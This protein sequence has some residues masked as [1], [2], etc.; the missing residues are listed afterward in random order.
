MMH[1]NRHSLETQEAFAR[2][3]CGQK[4]KLEKSIFSKSAAKNSA[5]E[6]SKISAATQQEALFKIK[7]HKPVNFKESFWRRFLRIFG[8]AGLIASLA[9]HAILFIV[10]GYFIIYHLPLIQPD[11]PDAFVTG[12]G[13]GN[14]GTARERPRKAPKVDVKPKRIASKN[15]NGKIVLPEIN[16]P[17][18]SALSSSI[19]A[20][21]GI[22]GTFGDMGSG[23][24][25]GNGGGIGAGTGI[26]VGDAKSFV[27]KFKIMGTTIKAQKLAVYLDCS[28]SMLRFLPAVK[29]EIY[30][31]FPDADTYEFNA[32][33]TQVRDGELVGSKRSRVDKSIV[34]TAKSMGDDKTDENKLSFQGRQIY[35]KYAANFA[36]GSVGAWL[37]IVL[38][39][40][41]DGLIIF[42]DFE[43]GLRQWDKN[44]RVIY[45]ESRYHPKLDDERK[46]K[47][48]R[49]FERWQ[50][51][52]KARRNKPAIY[53]YTIAR[54]PQKHFA[55]LVEMTG[56][57]ITDVSYLK[58]KKTKSKKKSKKSAPA[59][60]KIEVEDDAD[61]E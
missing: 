20:G 23:S 54:Q 13:G 25:G 24:G 6:R 29:E 60:P 15:S 39:S 28:G 27:S 61:D 40:H 58:A 32:I 49:W 37:D 18:V 16:M 12:A 47:D 46:A 10:A 7:N 1:W 43:D 3:R 9:F 2:E 36:T 51:I 33:A 31:L 30:A 14:N 38:E 41:Y 11:E 50:Q 19:G 22:A 42:S 57:E 5:R 59:E 52:V 4:V 53:C 8:G 17:S 35:R 55:K 26:G 44:D 21:T 48:L 45:A 34:K 56:G